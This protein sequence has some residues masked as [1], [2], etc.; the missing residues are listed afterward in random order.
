MIR[1]LESIENAGDATK[2]G[3]LRVHKCYYSAACLVA[4]KVESPIS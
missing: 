4:V 2:K 1:M 3:A